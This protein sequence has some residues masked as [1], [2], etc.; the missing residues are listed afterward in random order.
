MYID[1]TK[2]PRG[3]GYRLLVGSVMPRPIAWITSGTD[4]V[5]LAPF[6]AFTWV[7]IDPPM[8]G[9]TIQQRVADGSTRDKDTLHNIR[10]TGEYVVNIADESMLQVLHASSE[11]F[12]AEIGEP[13]QLGL[14]LT[15][16]VAVSVPRL[17]DVP[18]AMECRLDRVMQF[19]PTGGNFVVGT[20]VG[21]HV[22]DDVWG[23]D[24]ILHDRVHPIGRLAGPRYTRVDEI[25]ELPPVPGG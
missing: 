3:G 25:I 21:W 5:N 12:A 8:L 1:A 14:P 18:V 13:E 11:G 7:S 22:R 20:V 17:A 23:G 10:A 9:V 19:S 6:S 15:P 2:L 4:P 24:R 16:S